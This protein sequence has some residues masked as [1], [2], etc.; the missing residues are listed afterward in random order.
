MAA[1]PPGR[2]DDIAGLISIGAQDEEYAS[3]VPALVNGARGAGIEVDTRQYEGGHGW[4]VWS[5]ALADEVDW[6]GERL[7]LV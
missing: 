2:Y 5:A 7:G 4:A 1:A 6:L 3:A